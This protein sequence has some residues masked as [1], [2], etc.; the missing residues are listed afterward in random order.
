VPLR[1]ITRQRGRIDVVLLG[2]VEPE[3]AGR[4]PLDV[5]VGS[6]GDMVVCFEKL[7]GQG[8]FQ[9]L[10]RL[11]WIGKIAH[12][13]LGEQLVPVPAPLVGA[14]HIPVQWAVF[15]GMQ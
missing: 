9:N 14:D 3:V 2:R 4:H 15:E 10:Q 7:L 1:K 11:A 6:I 12:A 5:G 8:I 13:R